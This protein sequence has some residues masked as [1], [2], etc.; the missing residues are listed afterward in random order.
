M[1]RK[2]RAAHAPLGVFDSLE[3]ACFARKMG[4]VHTMFFL[5]G[6]ALKLQRTAAR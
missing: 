4:K 5:D 2:K 3:G 6:I 1:R